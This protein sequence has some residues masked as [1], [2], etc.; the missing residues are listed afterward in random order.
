MQVFL[1]RTSNFQGATIRPIVP[2][3]ILGDELSLSQ[4]ADD[5]NF[6]CAELAS[7]LEKAENFCK[8]EGMRFGLEG[9]KKTN[10]TLYNENDCLV[11][12]KF[13]LFMSPTIKMEISK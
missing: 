8:L 4:C 9:G 2:R 5:T 10:E 7:V 3:Q 11:R 12:L 6:F 1:S 13:E